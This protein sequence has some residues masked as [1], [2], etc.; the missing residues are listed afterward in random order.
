[1]EAVKV[2]V[3]G[4]IVGQPGCRAVFGSLQSLLKETRAD[5]VIANGENASEGLGITPEAAEGLFKSGIDL[6]T[7]GNHI[8]QRREIIPLLEKDKRILRPENYPTG[9]PGSGVSL[10][11]KKEIPIAVINLQGRVN[12]YSIRCPFR[13]GEALLRQL[14]KKTRVIVVDFHAELPEEKEA[15][16]LYLDGKISAL[17]GTHTHVQTA[18]EKILPRG[19]AYITDT[20]MTGPAGGVIGMKRDISINRSLMQI[21]YKMEV[22]DSAAVVMGVLLTIAVDSGK[23]LSIERIRRE[24]PDLKP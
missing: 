13:V 22:E 20:G 18:D 9:V 3:I 4:D 1:M 10:I 19:T 12:M 23:A 14:G 11:T 24:L 15:L 17:V 5:L 16:G 7:S 2:L 21:P 8:W 6:I